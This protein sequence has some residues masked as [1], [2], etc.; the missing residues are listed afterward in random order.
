[1]VKTRTVVLNSG[2]AQKMGRYGG[3]QQRISLGD[4]N[5]NHAGGITWMLDDSRSNTLPVC[6]SEQKLVHVLLLSGFT[7]AFMQ[8]GQFL[9]IDG[10]IAAF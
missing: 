2:E 8:S 4:V 1:M 7:T 9:V 10:N 6:T 5:N 3:W